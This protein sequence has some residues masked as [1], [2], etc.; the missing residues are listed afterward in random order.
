MATA[1][2]TVMCWVGKLPDLNGSLKQKLLITLRRE[3]VIS[4]VERANSLATEADELRAKAYRESL[5]IESQARQFWS[6]EQIN[7]AKL[8]CL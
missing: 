4:L 1:N 6:E 5:N 8:K 7:S 2:N 3:E